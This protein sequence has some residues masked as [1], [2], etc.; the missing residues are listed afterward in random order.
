[1]DL[2]YM[3]AYIKEGGDTSEFRTA[4]ERALMQALVR[5]FLITEEKKLTL[6]GERVF[7]FL[8]TDGDVEGYLRPKTGD[9][10]FDRF[11]K[12]YPSNDSIIHN[13]KILFKPTRS[14][15]AKKEE[16]AELF[17][18]ILGEGEF[19]ADQII[20]ALEYEVKAKTETSI[21]IRENKMRYMQN[22]STWLRQR[23]FAQFISIA[24]L[25]NQPETKSAG[26]VD[27]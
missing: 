7:E 11:W 27:I 8:Q 2:V 14:L 1:M 26:A 3:L 16:A 5:R 25:D 24:E 4:K 9:D 15:K 12:A 17:R 13:K 21:Q 22:S 20:K 6:D 19:T 18:Q 10:G 23:T